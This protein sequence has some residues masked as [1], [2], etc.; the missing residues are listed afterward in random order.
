MDMKT[1]HIIA[2]LFA[3]TAA[4]SC[5]KE[6][7]SNVQENFLSVS[8]EDNGFLQDGTKAALDNRNTVFTEGDKIGVFGV[9]DGNVIS[10]IN[11]LC[12]TASSANGSLTWTADNGKRLENDP[13][14][15]Y[16]AYFPY[17]F[18]HE[19]EISP[20]AS[21]AEGFFEDVVR[22]WL[23]PSDQS[24][25]ASYISSDLMIAEGN[26]TDGTLMFTMDHTMALI[27]I[28]LPKKHYVFT[29]TPAIPD[30][31]LPMDNVTFNGFE[32][33][34][35]DNVTYVYITNPYGEEKTFSGSYEFE[36]QTREWSFTTAGEAGKVTTYRIDKSLDNPEIMHNLQPGDFFLRDGSLLP[37]DAPAQTVQSADVVGIVF[38]TDP[39]RIG[40]GE[41]EALGG[42]AHA[43]VLA[44]KAIG[45]ATG[46][47][48]WFMTPDQQFQ[49]DETEIG[50]KEISD[51][52][53]FKTF[54]NVD[55]DLEGYMNNRLIREKR[56]GDFL[57][58]YYPVFKAAAE[59]GDETGGNISGT[60]GWYLPSGGQWFDILRNLAGTV[61]EA[62]ESDGFIA[63]QTG[64]I[65]WTDRGLTATNL[66]KR[67][68]NVSAGNKNEFKTGGYNYF[69]TSSAANFQ[70]AIY[71][72]LS[73]DIEGISWTSIMCVW[74][75][76]KSLLN[77]RAILAF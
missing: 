41:K 36:G 63:H 15:T 66:N 58:G 28:D 59:Y 10:S 50:M 23:I 26:I 48:E 45:G 21:D 17:E 7:V 31:V 9:K 44:T 32:P 29:N 77:A 42:N 8:V 43:L 75:Y 51:S 22:N 38:Q 68:E 13:D 57:A 11:N 69:W 33:L 4:I 54:E 34:P 16:F 46:Y 25:S 40:Q 53:P 19:E 72:G 74:D 2:A 73:D 12:M 52:D 5:T 37:K 64:D 49:R 30:Y 1:T 56:T 65:S 18:G 47:Y 6:T 3:A 61:L 39:D 70:G 67:M 60:T 20:E 76:K 27:L 14:I 62:D 71:I 55:S 24:S 35:D